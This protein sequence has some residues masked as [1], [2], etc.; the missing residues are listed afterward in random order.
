MSIFVS[1]GELQTQFYRSF[2]KIHCHLLH[3][4]AF[5]VLPVLTPNRI[6]RTARFDTKSHLSYCHTA[7][8]AQGPALAQ[9]LRAPEEGRQGAALRPQGAG[10]RRR[11]VLDHTVTRQPRHIRTITPSCISSAFLPTPLFMSAQSVFPCRP[12]GDPS[13]I[14]RRNSHILLISNPLHFYTSNPPN[15]LLINNIDKTR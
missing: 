7:P 10:H 2:G 8:L 9:G 1:F 13:V 15:A 14:L 4:I 11:G 6:Y 5:I 3:Q 12:F